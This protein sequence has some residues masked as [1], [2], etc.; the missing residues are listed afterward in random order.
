MAWIQPQGAPFLPPVPF[1]DGLPPPPGTQI[2]GLGPVPPPPPGAPALPGAQPVNIPG[3]GYGGGTGM[4]QWGGA[5]A[6]AL[7]AAGAGAAVA[8]GIM[9]NEMF[10]MM[11]LFGFVLL[12]FLLPTL[13]GGGTSPLST[14]MLL[15]LVIAG[16]VVFAGMGGGGIGS[17]LGGLGAGPGGMILIF[18]LLLLML[19]LFIPPVPPNL[20]LEG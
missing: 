8:T 17:L 4:A 2:V 7:A 12:I 9:G 15:F 1:P 6:G 11:M 14:G 5:G 20:P 3:G 16:L 19:F 10:L 13:T 18:G